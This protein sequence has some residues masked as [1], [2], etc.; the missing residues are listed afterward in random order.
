MINAILTFFLNPNWNPH[1]Q[2]VGADC[3]GWRSVVFDTE[4]PEEAETMARN[5]INNLG[6]TDSRVKDIILVVNYEGYFGFPIKIV[7]ESEKWLHL[8]QIWIYLIQKV[9]AL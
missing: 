8:N 7:K 1:G 4:T 3:S 6:V 9:F 2:I 5:Y